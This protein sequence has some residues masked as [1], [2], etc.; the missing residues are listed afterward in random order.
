MQPAEPRPSGS[1]STWARCLWC[2][3]LCAPL[4]AQITG[5]VTN[6]TTGKAQAGATVA[7]YTI[8]EAGPELVD[9]AK[10]DA[11]GNFT[12]NRTPPG[13]GPALIRTAF[14]GV[15]YNHMLPP[16]TPTTG[17]P[18]EIFNASRQPG[19]AKVAQHMILF[20][21]S[22]GQ[23]AV[24]E[25]YFIKNEGKT[26]WN[27]PGGGTLKFS[28]PAGAGKPEV[29]AT[30]PGG[31]SIGAPVLKTAKPDI[32]AVDFAIKPGQTQI[33]VTYAEPYTEGALLTGNVISQDENTYLL[34]SNGV[35]LEGDGLNDLGTD[36][37][38][39]KHVFGLTGAAYKVRLT[40]TAAAASGD[41]GGEAADESG[42]RME[43]IMPRVNTKT[44]S[45]L[46]VALGILALGFAL[47]YRK[48]PT[49]PKGWQAKAPAP[50]T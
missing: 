4:F 20:E 41:Q 44:V 31:M 3:L 11:R 34:V 17:I 46:I 37:R 10:S 7:L 2:F 36:P 29:T 32:F 16:G 49:A 47:L 14:D 28:L 50:P 21:P 38:T 25:V 30:A 1:V 9:Q 8:A 39:R 18:I 13:P 27:D 22:G 26:A 23:V 15:T 45:I 48:S 6:Q 35:T 33:D 19:G 24:D 42:P 43:Q 40:G 5:T 12:I